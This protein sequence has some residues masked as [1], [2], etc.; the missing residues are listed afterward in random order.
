[1]AK[2]NEK[3]AK[4]AAV[5]A[6]LLGAS[7]TA[8][9]TNGTLRVG[10]AALARLAELAPGYADYVGVRVNTNSVTIDP[11]SFPYVAAL[12]MKDAPVVIRSETPAPGFSV[13]KAPKTTA[14]AF[15][16]AKATPAASTGPTVIIDRGA[17]VVGV[18]DLVGFKSDIEQDG[19][20]VSI[21]DRREYWNRRTV[22]TVKPANGDHFYG[23][24]IGPRS[25]GESTTELDPEEC[26]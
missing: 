1:M 14:K 12:A 19:I 23:D 5:L 24:Y 15:P 6:E 8:V 9:N 18:G 4:A 7:G 20:I 21:E 13:P 16:G 3:T 25:T 26:W 11:T 22:I 10:N 2:R 17:R